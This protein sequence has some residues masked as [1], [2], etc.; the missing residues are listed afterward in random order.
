MLSDFLTESVFAKG[1]SVSVK[2]CHLFIAPVPVLFVNELSHIRKTVSLA[3]ANETATHFSGSFATNFIR[4][5][6]GCVTEVQ[7]WF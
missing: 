7:L 2:I 6:N 4:L 3:S 5:E 1:L